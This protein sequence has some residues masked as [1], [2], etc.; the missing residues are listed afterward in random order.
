MP[1][2]T[3]GSVKMCRTKHKWRRIRYRCLTKR[4]V[5]SQIPGMGC[6]ASTSGTGAA[7]VRTGLRPPQTARRRSGG[8]PDLT[9]SK[10]QPE[11]KHVDG[12][13]ESS[14]DVGSTPAIS[15]ISNWKRTASNRRFV[16]FGKCKNLR[17]GDFSGFRIFTNLSAPRN[18]LRR[19]F[20]TA[21]AFAKQQP[22]R[23][24]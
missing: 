13:A 3:L 20:C 4:R 6:P 23:K 18:A 10:D 21:F 8:S 14:Q 22:V 9:A 11:T 12:I 19:Q 15:T 7:A 24:Q 1:E 5:G 17:S 16:F 2:T